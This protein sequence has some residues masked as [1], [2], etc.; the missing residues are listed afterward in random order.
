MAIASGKPMEA[1][2]FAKELAQLKVN[3]SVVRQKSEESSGDEKEHKLVVNMYV[4]DKVSHRGPF[5]LNV[6]QNQT[7]GELKLQVEKEFEIPVN[8][9]RWILGKDLALDDKKTLEEF[10]LTSECAIFLYLV[11]PD[12]NKLKGETSHEFSKAQTIKIEEAGSVTPVKEENKTNKQTL[13]T[14]KANDEPTTSYN[15]EEHKKPTPKI[16]DVVPKN[17]NDALN[18]TETAAPNLTPKIESK[19]DSDGSKHNFNEVV[20]QTVTTVLFAPK[21]DAVYHQIE[22]NDEDFEVKTLKPSK[23]WECHL[24]T[25]LNPISTRVCQVCATVRLQ[26]PEKIPRKNKAAEKTQPSAPSLTITT[27]QTYLQLV[28]LDNTDLVNNVEPFEC[29][30]CFTEVP[31][32]KGVTLR[33]C[34]HQFCKECLQ[35]TIEFNEEIQVKCPYRDEQYS[36]NLPLQ[37]REI[38]N[39]VSKEKY[40][41]YL[42]KSIIQ[43]ENKID[44]SFHCKTPDCK[45]WCIFEDNVNEF[46]CP[47]CRR[48]NCLTCQAIHMGINCKQYQERMNEEAETDENAKRTKE[49]LQEMVNKGEALNCP[50]CQV[51]MMKKWGCDWLRCSMCKTE[52]CWVTKGPRWG[53]AGK[54][55]ISGGCQCGVNGVKC[56]PKCNYCH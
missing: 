9:Q 40:D 41:Q 36:C 13:P 33:E 27:D 51:V 45:G 38:K 48:V 25:L 44:K 42:A 1:A 11:A 21:E 35:N 22:D 15:I 52:I 47:V 6:K 2:N 23:E 55:D 30:I 32:M 3:C 14:T 39:L 56:H 29:L 50:T 24:C 18:K 46:R 53:P 31:P 10:K 43:A 20:T 16:I 26:A 8:V 19:R 17:Q 7:V 37:D 28:H 5:A 49:M 34:L 12:N 54:G 4:E